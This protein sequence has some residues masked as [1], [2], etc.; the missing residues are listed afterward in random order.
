MCLCSFCISCPIVIFSI[1]F[2]LLPSIEVTKSQWANAILPITNIEHNTDSTGYHYTQ[3]NYNCQFR[4]RRR[5]IV[6]NQ[7]L[8]SFIAQISRCSRIATLIVN[9]IDK[10][11]LVS[12][13]HH[14]MTLCKSGCG[15]RQATHAFF[16]RVMRNCR[17]F[18]RIF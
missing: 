4:S 13:V 14:I 8:K 12:V 9:I 7:N 16:I 10:G 3:T 2:F 11:E 17:Y 1:E 18:F 15:R 5:G 6:G